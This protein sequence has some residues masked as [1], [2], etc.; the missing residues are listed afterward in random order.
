MKMRTI[1]LP[2][3]VAVGLGVCSVGVAVAEGGEGA[4]DLAQGT[5]PDII[6]T[7]IYGGYGSY[8][9]WSRSYGAYQAAAPLLVQRRHHRHR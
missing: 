6:G 4:G 3:L 2:A 9:G 8:G 1:L 7:R 5:R